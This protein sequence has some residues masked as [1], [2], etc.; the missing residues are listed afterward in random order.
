M[1][2]ICP[3]CQAS[4]APDAKFCTSCGYDLRDIAPID[5]TAATT[6]TAD[7][8]V[9]DQQGT[10]PT[11]EM[12]NETAQSATN[13]TAHDASQST[14]TNTAPHRTT[15]TIDTANLQQA[16]QNYWQWL[17]GSWKTP[18]SFHTTSK[19]AGLITFAIEAILFGIGIGHYVQAA[20]NAVN[21]VANSTAALFSSTKS[22]SYSVS[23]GFYVAV[24]LTVF[25]CAIAMSGVTYLIS[26]AT[27][28]VGQ[29]FDFLDFLS[30][31]A[32]YSNLILILN[33]CFD[34]VAFISASGSGSFVLLFIILSLIP[35]VWSIATITAVVAD[36]A[37]TG[38]DC[39]Y[40]AIFTSIANSI[41]YAIAFSLVG[42]QVMSIV[43]DFSSSFLDLFS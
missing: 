38:L 12:P 41:I 33:I 21:G 10:Q 39:I 43:R 14:A 30:V 28:S 31:I 42:S 25:I 22:A 40:G 7:S 15:I 6:S 13:E 4:V 24:I 16:S 17:V 27:G 34:L 9:T 37:K 8:E 11:N 32:H 18:F 1:I 5:P 20:F 35:L 23:L 29:S 19:F 36:T 2:K 26:R 3:N